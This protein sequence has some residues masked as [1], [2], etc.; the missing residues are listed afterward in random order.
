[1]ARAITPVKSVKRDY[2]VREVISGVRE[3]QTDA[4]GGGGGSWTGLRPRG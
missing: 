3:L 4:R 2:G 1:M